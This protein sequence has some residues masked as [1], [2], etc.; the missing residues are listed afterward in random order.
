ME[1]YEKALKTAIDAHAGQVRKHDHSPYVAHPIMVARMLEK[2]G[3]PEV[4]VAAALTHDVLEDTSVTEEDLRNKL[5]NQVVDI[6]VAVSEEKAL[7]WEE[8][9]AAYVKQVVEA[10]ESVWAVSVADKIHNAADFIQFHAAAGPDAWKVFNRGKDKKIWFENL[11]YAE[12]KNVWTHP[13]MD[14]YARLIIE[15]EQLAD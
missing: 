9:K 5:G 12:L 14:E 1:L 10:N 13:L 3:F 2:A 7:P 15:L 4:V 11:L 6:V 8:R